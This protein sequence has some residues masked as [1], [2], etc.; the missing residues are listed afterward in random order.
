MSV[1]GRE[2]QVPAKV[3]IYLS[4]YIKRQQ[5]SFK[6]IDDQLFLSIKS[7]IIYHSLVGPLH[8]NIAVH[9][10]QKAHV[11]MPVERDDLL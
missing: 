10:S 8:Q 6:F 3:L 4:R 7:I 9:N 5:L 1:I 11:L 2:Q